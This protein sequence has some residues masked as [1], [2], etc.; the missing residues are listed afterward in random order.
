MQAAIGAHSAGLGIREIVGASY[1]SE[2]MPPGSLYAVWFTKLP[3]EFTQPLYYN[4]HNK[5]LSGKQGE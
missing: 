3:F 4:I 2:Q 5:L 1:A